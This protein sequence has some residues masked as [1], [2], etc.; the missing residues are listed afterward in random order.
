MNRSL[1]RHRDSAGAALVAVIVI[2]IVCGAIAASA[3]YSLVG[4]RR[5]T[6]TKLARERAFQAAEAG[7]DWGLVKMRIGH[8]NLPSP[9]DETITPSPAGQTVISYRS[10]ATNGSD[11]DGDGAVDE[12]DEAAYTVITSTGRA[13]DVQR[14]LQLLVRKAV[15]TPAFPASAHIADSTPV[16]DL[17]GNAFRISGQDHFIDGTQDLTRPAMFGLTSP[18]NPSVLTSQV[19]SSSTGN[20]TGSGGSPSIGQSTAINLD[21]LVEQARSAATVILP[22]GT[23]TSGNWGTPTL[24]GVQVVYAPGDVKLAGGT[25]GAGVLV[26]DGDLTITGGIQWVGIILVRGGVR[27]AGGGGTNLLIGA[28][29]CADEVTNDSLSVSGTVDLEYSS[30]AVLL[31]TN[32]LAIPVVCTWR[33]T[34]AP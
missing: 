30:D 8:G 14:T 28:L 19:S 13:N 7:I 25:A 6:D 27:F 32:A 15:V 18:A 31:A 4:A 33:E 3:A 10:G 16:L 21:F 24:S 34:G 20:I 1:S 9:A 5:E 26:V 12:A 11:D 22:S 17:N 23:V 2:V 29:A